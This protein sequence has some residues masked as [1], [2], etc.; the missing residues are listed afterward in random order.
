MEPEG[1]ELHS[2]LACRKTSLTRLR[3]GLPSQEPFPRRSIG[4]APSTATSTFPQE[5]RVPTLHIWG[6][7]DMALGED[8]AM[9]TRDFVKGPYQFVRLA[10]HAHWLPN[11]GEPDLQPLILAHLRAYG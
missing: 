5:I 11:E 4:I 1:C 6:E 2:T 7:N 9:R 3:G 10:G 8:A